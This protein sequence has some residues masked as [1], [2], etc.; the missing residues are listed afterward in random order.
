MA[1]MKTHLPR[2]TSMCFPL[3]SAPCCP[4][5]LVLVREQPSFKV[6][7]KNKLAE[8]LNSETSLDR[9]KARW[10]TEFTTPKTQAGIPVRTC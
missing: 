8:M 1:L 7:G 4:A 9:P 6:E 2:F 5:F 10:L 3:G